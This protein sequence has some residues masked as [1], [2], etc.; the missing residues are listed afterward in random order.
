VTA[1]LPLGIISGSLYVQTS[2]FNKEGKDILNK[3]NNIQYKVR[4]VIF[5]IQWT[6]RGYNQVGDKVTIFGKGIANR[7]VVNFYDNTGKKLESKNA[8]IT[9][10]YQSEKIEVDVTSKLNVFYVTVTAGGI[11]SEKTESLYFQAGPKITA[12]KSKFSRTA[13]GSRDV[14]AAA[15]VGE[16]IVVNGDG[17]KP[18]P[19]NVNMEIQGVNGVISVP[20]PAEMIDA[21]GKSLKVTV[22]VGAQAGYLKMIV[23]GQRSN[24]LPVEIVPTVISISPSPI[25][26]GKN[27]TITANGVGSNTDLAF[28]YF[29]LDKKEQIAMHP[30]SITYSGNYALLQMKAPMAIASKE[31]VISLQ[32]DKWRDDGKVALSA[33]PTITSA[34]INLDNKVLTIKGHGFSLT[35]ADN[36]ITYMYADHTVI[37]PK[38]KMLGVYPTEE[39]QEIRVQITDDYRY[40]YVQVKVGESVSNEMNFGPVMVTRIARRVELVKSTNQ[41]MGVLYISGYNFGSQ[42]G[43]KVGDNW[44]TVHY[45]SDKFII[46]VIDQRYLYDDP[47]IVAK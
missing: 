4:P 9:E 23:N 32:Y 24:S 36:K 47:V 41:V 44:A 3:S 22:P 5:D 27:M 33:S 6:K 14:I 34:S 1:K 19:G 40:G 38:V 21:N 42:G 30:E 2:F 7:P 29:D 28:V 37:T 31:S 13:A 25:Q 43:V 16:E 35:P 8:K 45:R 39:G 26:P 12:I 46:A 10:I 15:K 17:L 20:V 11:E 18:G